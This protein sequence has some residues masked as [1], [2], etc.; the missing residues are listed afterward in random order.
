MVKDIAE[1]VR[2]TRGKVIYII[3][4]VT[5]RGETDGYSAHQHL[6]TLESYL[7]KNVIDKIIINSS[8]APR[9]P[10]SRVD[11]DRGNTMHIHEDVMMMIVRE[12]MDEATCYAQYRAA[13]RLARGPR[14][15]TRALLGMALIRFGH[16]MMGQSTSA[17]GAP[18]NLRQAQS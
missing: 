9:S 7:V 1:A 14:P 5:Q 10:F 12:R 15:S 6:Q 2:K 11:S 13:L 4:I 17:S 3:N 16:W 18:I 8:A